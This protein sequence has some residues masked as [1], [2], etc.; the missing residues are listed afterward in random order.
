ML[1]GKLQIF[2][3]EHTGSVNYP[4][5]AQGMTTPEELLRKYQA[6]RAV[7]KAYFKD[8]HTDDLLRAKAMERE[9]DKEVQ[10]FFDAAKNGEQA[11]MEL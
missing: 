9:L 6:L 2:S 8:R 1:L 10:A 11:T 5:E 7:Q 4:K 3:V